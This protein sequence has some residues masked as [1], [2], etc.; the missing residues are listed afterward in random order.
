MNAVEMTS[1]GVKELLFGPGEPRMHVSGRTIGAARGN[2]FET[3]DPATSPALDD[4]CR[5]QSAVRPL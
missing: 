3:S 1:F 4:P 2:A 5:R